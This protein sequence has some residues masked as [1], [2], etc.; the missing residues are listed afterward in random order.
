[1]KIDNQSELFDIFLDNRADTLSSCFAPKSGWKHSLAS[2]ICLLENPQEQYRMYLQEDR[3][4]KDKE[5]KK[6]EKEQQMINQKKGEENYNGNRKGKKKKNGKKVIVKEMK[7]E[8]QKA[9]L[10]IQKD[11]QKLK[12]KEHEGGDG[13]FKNKK[14]EQE[15]V[16]K[17]EVMTLEEFVEKRFKTIGERLKFCIV[18]LYTHLPTSSISLELVRNM[19]GALGLLASLETLLNS[20]NIAKQG[21]KQVLG[22]DENA[23]SITSSHMKLSMTRKECLSILKSLPPTFPVPDFTSTFAIKEFCLANACLLF[24]TT[25]SSIKLHTKRMT[26][27]RFLVID[28][29]AQLKECESTIPLQL[30][31][32]HHA[33]LV[34]DERQLSAMVNSKISEEAGFGRS[35]FERLVKLGYKKHLLNIQYRMHPSISLLPNREFYG[36]QILDALNVKE[37]SHER[38]FLEGNMY[39]SYS[40]INISHGKEEFDEFRSL[41]NM[42]EVAVVSDI[43]AN[44]FSEF[45]STKKKVSIGIISPYKAQVHAIQEKIGNY[46][47]G[48]DAEFSVNVRS[49]DG[50]QG[51]EEDVIIFSTVRCNNKGSVGFLSNCQRANVALTRAR[52]CLWILGNAATLNKSGSIWKKLVADAERRRCFHNADEDNRLAQA[53]IAA[54]IELDQLDTLLQAT[55]PLFRKARWK[56]F[57]SDD[58]QRSME[59]LKDVEIRKKVISL[60]EKLSNGWRQSDKDNDQIVHDGISFQLLQQYKVNEQLNIVWS[61][62][63]LQENSFQ[64]QVLKI[65]DVLSSSHVA[66][67]AESL[68]NL[69]RKYTIDKINC[70]KYKCFERNLVVPMRWPVNSSNVHRGST[71][72]TNLLQLSESLAALSLRDQSS[73]STTANKYVRSLILR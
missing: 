1:M 72:G 16:A 68:D 11:K 36:K 19:I 60:L 50:F 55:S 32:L 51:G 20:V 6:V 35:L 7:K 39:S 45:I 38:R 17:C 61:V 18:N 63:I 42:V 64:I 22:I 73:S 3:T 53:I 37:I 67:L 9:S 5:D 44:L 23:G 27:L 48:S 54:L 40:F 12:G 52:Y 10:H 24:C 13:Y 58:F 49:I 43:V 59:R 66:K 46:S 21:F 30:S 14:T 2:M 65:W 47:S 25:S 70:C 15:V 57:F 29:A 31:G 41:R 34:G 8:E 28:E 69:F 56:V 71:S 33:I 26:P 62:D 4:E